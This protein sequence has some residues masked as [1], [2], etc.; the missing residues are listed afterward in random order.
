MKIGLVGGSSQ[1]RSLPFNAERT[2]NLYPVI[3]QDGKE[4]ASMYGTPGLL[5]FGQAGSGAVRGMF[6]STNG[7]AF[8]VSD[9]KLYEIDSAGVT[10]ER[11][12][13]LGSSGTVSIDENLTQLA[14]CD[15]VNLYIF[16]YATNSF[17]QV[18]DADLPTSVGSVTFIDNYF[19]VNKNNTGSF[20]ISDV[21][22]GASWQALE[23][24]TAE[25]SPDNLKR[26]YNGLGQLFLL[27]ERTTEIWT[28]T[29]ASNFPFS[30]VSGV[31]IEVGILAPFSVVAINSALYWLGRDSFGSGNVYRTNGVQPERITTDPI[32]KI[33][34]AASNKQDIVAYSYQEEGHDFYVLT[35]GGLPTTLVYDIAT[36]EWHER[37]F[38]ND[39]G[40]YEQHLGA[41]FMVAFDKLLVGSRI[42]G[43]I[44]EMSLNYYDDAGE[45][46][47]R[48]RTY[49]HIADEGRRLR[50]NSL[51]IG[52]ET[53][54]GNVS[55]S[56]PYC[57][58]RLSRDGGR[59]WGDAETKPIGKIGEYL[60]K[61]QFRRLGVSEQMTFDLQISARVKIAI[62][63]SY[64]N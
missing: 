7:R 23:F 51:E 26:V 2:V 20:Y 15:Q 12:S 43:K 61:V 3:D 48:Q 9:S 60:T 35:G 10:T 31:K 41:F 5:L 54:V 58:L 55:D 57:S 52:F 53:G 1:Q 11:G 64:L 21:A 62:T 30:R 13:L 14:I 42:D 56:D 40:L 47:R 16:T 6:S 63:G 34:Q 19:V 49:T 37:A 46:I 18:T 27:G 32:A 25:S 36:Q 8:V 22:N 33:I 59:T 4:S 17:A 29:G 38:L 44:Y 50:F 45:E 39:E 28:N 24:A